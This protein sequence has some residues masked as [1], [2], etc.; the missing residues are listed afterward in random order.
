MA[1][2]TQKCRPKFVQSFS[3]RLTS[4]S[5]YSSVR[6]WSWATTGRVSPY[7]S[8]NDLALK[9]STWIARD[10]QRLGATDFRPYENLLHNTASPLSM[11]PMRS[12]GMFF[13]IALFQKTPISCGAWEIPSMAGPKP[14]LPC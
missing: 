13:G 9:V 11:P 6:F 10:V 8:Q 4:M 3:P 12:R 7:S 5:T 2:R 14:L 1:N